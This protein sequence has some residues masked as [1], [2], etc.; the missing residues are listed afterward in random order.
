MTSSKISLEY[1]TVNSCTSKAVPRDAL[2]DR[3]A[4]LTRMRGAHG[5]NKDELQLLEEVHAEFES[6]RCIL[7]PAAQSDVQASLVEDVIQRARVA[8]HVRLGKNGDIYKLIGAVSAWKFVRLS[9][10]A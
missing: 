2:P 7:A 1:G 4:T 3:L 5:A 10:R 9:G 6:H 8:Q